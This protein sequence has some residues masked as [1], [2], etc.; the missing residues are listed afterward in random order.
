MRATAAWT[1]VTSAQSDSATCRPTTQNATLAER[2][3]R[4]WRRCQNDYKNN[5]AAFADDG[6]NKGIET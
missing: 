1:C 6:L 2:R 4:V 5:F 3:K